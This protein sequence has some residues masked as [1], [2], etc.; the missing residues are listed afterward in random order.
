MGGRGRGLTANQEGSE[1]KASNDTWV[2]HSGLHAPSGGHLYFRKFWAGM[3]LRGRGSRAPPPQVRKQRLV[4]WEGAWG[5]AFW[6]KKAGEPGLRLLVTERV[7]LSQTAAI[8]HSVPWCSHVEN[9]ALLLCLLASCT[10]QPGR[11]TV[12]AVL[13]QPGCW[14]LQMRE[15]CSLLGPGPQRTASE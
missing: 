6:V 8:N 10:S 14:I 12:P 3:T 13:P 5:N 1:S 11:D 4:L 15:E 9:A 7:W 2:S